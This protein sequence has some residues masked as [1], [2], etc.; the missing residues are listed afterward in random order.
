VFYVEVKVESDTQPLS[1]LNQLCVSEDLATLTEE[2]NEWHEC[3]K[4]TRSDA[5]KLSI[6]VFYGL[7]IILKI[8]LAKFKLI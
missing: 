1:T 2:R 7:E 4:L 3:P 5:D 8:L 6:I